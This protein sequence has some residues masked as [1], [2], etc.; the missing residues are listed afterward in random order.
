[1]FRINPASGMLTLVERLPSGGKTPRHFA[2][3]PSGKWLWVANQYSNNLSLFQID[4]GNGRL[5]PRSG[6][7]EIIS[8][9]CVCFVPLH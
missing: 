3:D 6:A 4:P 9:V 7:L 1:V 5:V 8:P 2:L